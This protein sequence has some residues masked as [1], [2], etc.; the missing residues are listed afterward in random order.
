MEVLM[1]STPLWL[2][3]VIVFLGYAINIVTKW[4]DIQTN[5]GEFLGKVWWKRNKLNVLL[6]ILLITALLLLFPE[7]PNMISVSGSNVIGERLTYLL[8]GYAPYRIFKTILKKSPI[9]LN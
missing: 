6:S 7:L 1:T 8:I 4:I 3:L 2:G 5:G 9:K